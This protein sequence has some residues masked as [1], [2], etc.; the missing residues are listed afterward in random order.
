M[1]MTLFASALLLGAMTTAAMAAEPSD[2]TYGGPVELTDVQMDGV[3]AAGQHRQ[4]GLVN[5]FIEERGIN[6]QIPVQVGVAAFDSQVIQ[7]IILE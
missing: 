5:V 2:L 7:E 4:E 6:V 1:K 3:T